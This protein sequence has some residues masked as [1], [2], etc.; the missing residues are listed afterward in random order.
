M[1]ILMVSPFYYPVIGGTERF[2]E[3]ISTR[4]NHLGFQTDILTFNISE[5]METIPRFDV[6]TSDSVKVFKIPVLYLPKIMNIIDSNFVPKKLPFNLMKGYDIIHYHN[7]TDLTL[8]FFTLFLKKP[9]IFHFHCLNV[10][11]PYLRRKAL[12]RNLLKNKNQVY[13]VVSKYTANLLL[14][15]GFPKQ[16]IRIVPNGVDVA[17]F[18]PSI[19]P[20]KENLLLFVGRIAPQKG[21][22]I[23]LEALKYLKTKVRLLIIGSSSKHYLWYFDEVMEL[24]KNINNVTIHKVEYLGILDIAEVV[25]LYRQASLFVCPSIDEPFG[26]VNLEALSCGTPVVASNAGGIPEFIQHGVHGLLV[27]RNDPRKFA[28]ALQ[29][30]LDNHKVRKKMGR[31]GRQYV[32]ENFSWDTVSR[33]LCKIY[34]EVLGEQNLEVSD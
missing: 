15:M 33:K 1:K 5:N 31:A 24:I 20:K 6:S 9:K 34:F 8:P 26:I 32:V 4:L 19:A 11:Y 25:E 30:L 28:D 17:R 22:T 27:P 12:S 18:S 14:D 23:L 10:T 16:K 2:I 13:I 3:D 21:L 7:D 29:Y